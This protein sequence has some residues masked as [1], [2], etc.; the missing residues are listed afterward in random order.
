M[1]YYRCK[2]GKGY[3]YT[4]MGVFPC[5]RC[6]HCGSD[7]AQ[8]PDNHREPKPHLLMPHDVETDEGIATLHRCQW[9]GARKA[10]IEAKGEPFEYEEATK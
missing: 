3:A 8:H 4:S 10:E 2:C 9:C 1:Q 6:R 7:Y 5:A